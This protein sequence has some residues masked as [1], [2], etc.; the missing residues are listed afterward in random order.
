MSLRLVPVDW[1]T[2]R[3]RV[4][5]WYPRHPPPPGYLWARGVAAGD[6]LVGVATVGRPVVRQ[7]ANGLTVEVTSTVTDGARAANS[8]LYAAVTRAA[9]AFGYRRFVTY[10][11]Q[12]ETGSSLR[13]AGY[14]VI[15]QRPP[16]SGWT[17]RS[18]PRRDHGVDDV[19][20]TLWEATS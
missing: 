15:A 16:R 12:G 10:T 6:V 17:T 14:R 5:T 18:R 1:A 9:L 3:A 19:A 11:Q 2:A 13:A 8:M 4:A 7:L 20:R